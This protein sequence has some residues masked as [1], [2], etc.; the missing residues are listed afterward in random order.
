MPIVISKVGFGLFYI[1]IM[2]YDFI[3]VSF[4]SITFFKIINTIAMAL[5]IFEI[6][7]HISLL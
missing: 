1:I 6:W 5:L 7:L 2:K 3:E 4:Y